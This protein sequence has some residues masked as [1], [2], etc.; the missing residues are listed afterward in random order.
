MGF[1]RL[2]INLTSPTPAGRH[3]VLAV[4]VY[5]SKLIRGRP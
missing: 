4:R 1:L 2:E 5:S 3:L